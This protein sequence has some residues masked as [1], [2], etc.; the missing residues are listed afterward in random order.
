MASVADVVSQAKR[1]TP[2]WAIFSRFPDNVALDVAVEE[3]T[4]MG[5]FALARHS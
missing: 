2:L 3:V 4:S 5:R 1:Q